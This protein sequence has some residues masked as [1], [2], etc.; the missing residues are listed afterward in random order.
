[1]VMS[2]ART[3]L[4]PAGLIAGAIGYLF[5]HLDAGPY[6]GPV[7]A[8]FIVLLALPSYAALVRW[9][10][11]SRALGILFVLSVLPVT[12]E[13]LAIV[14]GFPYGEFSY[15]GELGYRVFG[16]V[17]WTVA[18]A[19]LP[20]LLGSIAVAS[21]IAGT[22]PA[23]LIVAS[24]LVLVLVDLVVDPALVHAGMW[25]W[26][27]GGLYYGIPATNFLGWFITGSIY[28]GIFYMAA[29]K[30]LSTGLPV[31]IAVSSSLLLI[32]GLWT[33]YLFRAGL[34]VP[35]VIGVLLFVVI[36]GLILSREK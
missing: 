15:A 31:S 18:F 2:L 21:H 1:M 5:L 20:M 3:A 34:L 8:A 19:Y 24:G 27:G 30:E 32:L 28:A 29:R 17:P 4:I 26:P 33:G 14:T 10:P 16:L 25:V 7:S 12:V 11:S 22:A 9:L 13:A 23:R 36:G 6:T 35:A